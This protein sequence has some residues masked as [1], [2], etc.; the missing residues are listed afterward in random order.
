MMN[1]KMKRF[2][3][4]I[5]LCLVITSCAGQPVKFNE[6]SEQ[7]Y[8]AT[9]PKMVTASACGFQLLL[10][11]PININTRARLAFD[12]LISKAGVDYVVKDIKVQE[13]WYYALIGTVYCTEFEGTAYPKILGS[14]NP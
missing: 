10:V 13:K 8:D 11:I 7:K 4:I 14:Q 3:I 5:A 9:K 2:G 6:L 12:S 1:I